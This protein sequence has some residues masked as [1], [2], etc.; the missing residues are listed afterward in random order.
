MEKHLVEEGHGGALVGDGSSDGYEFAALD[1]ALAAHAAHERR[2]RG[3]GRGRRGSRR[4]G[5]SGR[6]GGRGGGAGAGE[7][8]PDRGGGVWL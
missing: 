7:T 4:H 8:T 2:V 3:G 1:L 5:P 6:G